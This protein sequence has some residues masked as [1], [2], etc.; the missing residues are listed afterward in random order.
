M[1][2]LPSSGKSDALAR[3]LL[4]VVNEVLDALH[5]EIN[6]VEQDEIDLKPL[7]AHLT[8]NSATRKG[9]ACISHTAQVDYASYYLQS[10]ALVE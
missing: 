4:E 3:R 9:V 2:L 10:G 8:E 5:G 1:S 7:K 6:A